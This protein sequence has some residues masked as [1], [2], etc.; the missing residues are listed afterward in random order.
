MWDILPLRGGMV[1]PPVGLSVGE[2]LEEEAVFP[3][4]C[5]VSKSVLQSR[6]EWI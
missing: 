3:V 1:I 2:T 4:D 5:M 6:S